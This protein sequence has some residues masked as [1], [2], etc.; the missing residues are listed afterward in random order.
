MVL[1]VN[2][3]VS[4]FIEV[5]CIVVVVDWRTATVVVLD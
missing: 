5:K 4:E 3:N 1:F 2:V